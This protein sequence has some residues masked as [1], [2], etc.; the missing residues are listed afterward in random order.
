MLQKFRLLET[1]KGVQTRDRDIVCVIESK[2]VC[3]FIHSVPRV[4]ALVSAH[5]NARHAHDIHARLSISPS[6]FFNVNALIFFKFLYV[7]NQ[8]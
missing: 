3:V 6:Y 8:V 5:T 2:C 7:K 1:R 4:L